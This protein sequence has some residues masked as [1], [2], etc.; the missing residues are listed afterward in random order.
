MVVLQKKRV[1]KHSPSA[2]ALVHTIGLARGQFMGA[3]AERVCVSAC[4][5]LGSCQ[6]QTQLPPSVA[7]LA[8]A[9]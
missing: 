9:K 6:Q 7:V 3:A 8:A 5:L 2:A 1:C 4:Q